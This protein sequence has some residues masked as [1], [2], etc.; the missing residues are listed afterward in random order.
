MTNQ[1]KI[2]NPT[3][4]EI[5]SLINELVKNDKYLDYELHNVNRNKYGEQVLHIAV[6]EDENYDYFKRWFMTIENQKRQW[7]CLVDCSPNAWWGGYGVSYIG[8]GWTWDKINN[9]IR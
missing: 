1:I 6:H 2:V 3:L 4:K 7:R 8:N 5:N 9:H